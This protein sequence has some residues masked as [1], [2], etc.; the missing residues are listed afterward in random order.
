MVAGVHDGG[1]H[2]VV[3]GGIKGSRVL[4]GNVFSFGQNGFIIPYPSRE[5]KPVRRAFLNFAEIWRF[6]LD[7]LARRWY[8]R[9]S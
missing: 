1:V 8:H 4:H 5:H 7:G 9:D 2:A 3:K 6:F